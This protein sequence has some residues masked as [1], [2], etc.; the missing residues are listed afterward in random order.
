LVRVAL[1]GFNGALNPAPAVNGILDARF[2]LK[3]GIGTPQAELALSYGGGRLAGIDVAAADAVLK[4]DVDLSGQGTAVSADNLAGHAT[5][6]ASARQF[7]LS[8]EIAPVEARIFAEVTAQ[9]GELTVNAFS[10]RANDARITAKGTYTIAGSHL[11]GWV[12]VNAPDLRRSLAPWGMGPISG[13]LDARIGVQGHLNRPQAEIVLEADDLSIHTLTLGRARVEAALNAE[14]ALTVTK[15]EI[16]NKGSRIR[17]AGTVAVPWRGG[18]GLSTAPSMAFTA[19]MTGVNIRDF[20]PRSG[21]SG[22]INANLQLSGP[23]PDGQA[24]VDARAQG[25]AF[26]PV[27]V[28]RLDARLRW[29]D[30]RLGLDRFM[31]VSGRS[32]LQIGGRII[33]Y[34]T[35]TGK[36]HPRPL[37]EDLSISAKPLYL[38][39]AVRSG[40]GRLDLD[41]RMSGPLDRPV[42]TM[43]IQGQDL[44]WQGQHLSRLK[45]Q[46][47]PEG[48]HLQVEKIEA[49]LAPGQPISGSG[50]VDPGGT[51]ALNLAAGP[52]DLENI[53]WIGSRGVI[54]GVLAVDLRAGGPLNRPDIKAD[55]D[56]SRLRLRGACLDDARFKLLVA[57]GKANLTGRFSGPLEAGLNLDSRRLNGRWDLETDHLAPF[58]AM[59]GLAGMDGSL[60]ALVELETTVGDWNRLKAKASVNRLELRQDQRQ[61][62]RARPFACSVEEKRLHIPGLDLDLLDGGRLALGGSL[63]LAGPIDLGAQGDIPLEVLRPFF[64]DL[65][66]LTGRMVIQATVGGT[67]ATPRFRGQVRIE[68]AGMTLPVVEQKIHALSALIRITPEAMTIENGMG[69]LDQSPFFFDGRAGL[70][71][72]GWDT[73][74]LAL[75][76]D[77]L[78]VNLPKPFPCAW[79]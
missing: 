45:I 23:L 48:P 41:V 28:E 50:W 72:L 44:A 59:A 22:R 26:G 19:A 75:R 2:S 47:R 6:E 11:E 36:W 54:Q 40:A 37:L 24:I 12:Q 32:T 43:A 30:G 71:G 63:A 61:L 33:V 17:G 60:A 55:L 9:K 3:G 77:D 64:P 34:D 8:K 62:I 21:V 7:P 76:A 56:F 68:Q 52:I 46:A 35:A 51:F 5:L 13:R 53:A 27:G 78:P 20:A 10:A 58:L 4:V 66:D 57:K 39:D 31:A 67:T 79:V 16:A 1:E 65:E 73:V 25:L 69:H 29:Q 18:S 15:L 74:A 49:L 14:G 38:Q 42:G 70:R